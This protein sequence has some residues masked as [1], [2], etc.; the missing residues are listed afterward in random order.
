[1]RLWSVNSWLEKLVIFASNFKNLFYV[2]LVA[3]S[4]E[5]GPVPVAGTME[6]D[7]LVS[8]VMSFVHIEGTKQVL[9]V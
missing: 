2:I 6:R 1:M 3:G 5:K 9:K 4:C 8:T 7:L